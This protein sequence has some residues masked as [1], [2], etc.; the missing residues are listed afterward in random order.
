[1]KARK[2]I[3][4]TVAGLVMACILSATE[5]ARG[6]LLAAWQFD[7]GDVVGNSVSPSGGSAANTTGTLI[8]GAD[9]SSGVLQLDGSNDYLQFGND[10]T[11][12]R[13][14]GLSSMTIAAWVKVGDGGTGRRRIVEHEDNIYFW[15]ESGVYQYTTH[16]T[17]GGTDG[18]AISTTPPAIGIWQHV[19]VTRADGQ[20]ARIYIDGV[21]QNASSINQAN[22]PNNMH[23]LQIGARRDSSGAPSAFFNG[24]LDDVAIWNEILPLSTIEELAGTNNGGYAG[25][26][27]P[28]GPVIPEPSTFLLGVLASLG[29]AS[30][31]PRR[32][33][34]R[35]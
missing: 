22:M 30:L 23:T 20:P 19:L 7:A 24:E 10:V 6:D 28:A 9:A 8:G 14:S 5:S 15:T 35:Q 16:G 21:F 33:R 31:T 32:R 27:M 4:M 18:R 2:T 1:M 17:P 12:L 29:I 34:R 26:T 13:G 25:R 11:D 3:A